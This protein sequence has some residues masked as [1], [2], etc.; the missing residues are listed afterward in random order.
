MLTAEIKDIFTPS[1]K[2]K[3]LVITVGNSLRSDDGV[4]IYIAKQIKKCKKN[5]IILNADS[6]PE[7]IID[8]A[9][10]IKPQKVVIIDAA[11]FGGRVGEI[12]LIKKTDIQSTSL[13]THSFF[14]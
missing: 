13:S 6:K 9:V 2:G 14:F 10:Q 3:L 12:R 1:E 11:D 7:N 5:I 8:K 4:G